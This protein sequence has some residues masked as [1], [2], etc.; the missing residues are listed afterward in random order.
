VHPHAVNPGPGKSASGDDLAA[1]LEQAEAALR[2]RKLDL[3][4]M[5]DSI[6]AQV[7][8]LTPTGEVVTLNQPCLEYFGKTLEDLKGWAS[9]DPVHPEDLPHVIEVLTHALE[10]GETYEV[11]SRHRRFDGVY[12]WFHV[13]GFPLRDIEGSILR[14]CVL[15]TDIDDRK[16]AEA[17]RDRTIQELQAQQSMLSESEQR[18]RAIFDEAGTGMALVDL[19]HPDKPIQNNRALQTMLGLSQ[20]ELSLLETFNQ[21]TAVADRE[22]DAAAFRELCEGKRASLRQE[23]HFILPDGC[24]VWANVIF[25]LLRDSAGLP[26]FVIAI[27]QDITGRKRAVEELQ[28]KQ[29]LL[30]L[31]QKSARA[32]AFDWY[33]QQE[34]NVWSPQQEALYGLPP[35]SFDGTYQ[36][37][38]KLIY[39][40]DWPLLLKAIT[41]AHGTGDVSVE[42]RVKWP[43][44]SLHWLS[45]NGQMFFDDQGKPFRMVGFTADI[46]RRK[47]IEEELRRSAAF[48]AQAQ[49]LSRTGS[50]SWRVATDEIA[51]SEELYRIYEF[52]PGI[53]ITFD[54]I[55]TRVHPEDLTLYEKMVEQGRNG[56]DD[57]EWQ[58]R[59]L[60]PDQSIKYMHAVAQATRDPNGQLEYI[61][62]VQDV[63]RRKL[64]EEE[65]RRSEA[66]LAEGQRLSTTGSFVWRPDSDEIVFSDELKRIFGFE[67]GTPVTLERIV[68]CVHPDDMSLVAEKIAQARAGGG[69]HDYE[70]RLRMPDGSVK[71]LHTN[72]RANR[73]PDGYLEFVGAMQDVTLRRLAEE[74][75]GKARSELAHATRIMSL[76]VLTA[77][78]AHEVNQP[79]SGIIT[80]ASTC[81]RMLDGDPPN[82]DGARE[83]AKRTIRD[84]RRAADV[85]ARLRALFTHKNG[86]TEFVDLNEATREV[87]SLSRTE[88]ERNG[89][90]A[91]IELD[92][93]LPPVIGD[94]VQLQ[95]VILNLLRNG[96]DAMRDVDDRP[97]ELLFRTEVEEPDRVRLSVQDA[98]IGLEPQSLHR[99]FQ[100]FYTTKEE[101]MGIGLAVSHSIIE[102]HRG[103]LWA[104]PNDGP[105]VTFSFSIP[106]AD[107][108]TN[109]PGEN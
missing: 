85:I 29:D 56:A 28:A 103:R 80:N 18:F 69:D 48:L 9:S 42:F 63:T 11:E 25:T 19:Q 82:V 1:R 17:Q 34:V 51:W 53:T 20:E 26:R 32:M 73:R 47:I 99:L 3:Q 33:I 4:L 94:R 91:K 41:H 6:P 60:M 62:A 93:E 44:G 101:G 78:I 31:A 70:I 5:V 77:S 50:F 52:D 35:G 14:W 97:R 27:H 10:T 21:L 107:N 76:G 55:R 64:I 95:Q 108:L 7:A 37:W 65:M 109:H 39:A 66:F 45:T 38:K 88:L 100:T 96:A 58:Y 13:R 15:L 30:D 57:F 46:S 83:T 89:V 102:N 23:K 81:V 68:G 36:S 92:D 106:H 59:L 24:S 40:P 22:A 79:L 87:I 72:A 67:L 43:D 74:A 54:I 71:Y 61:A 105:G 75:L 84:G 104:T 98:G 16:R 49:Q 2:E 90:I 86:A 8:V 12:R